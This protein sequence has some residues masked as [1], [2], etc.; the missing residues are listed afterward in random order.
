MSEF[1][2][3][4]KLAMAALDWAKLTYNLGCHLYEA[5]IGTSMKFGES[6]DSAEEIVLTEEN[7]F[8][9]RAGIAA[10]LSCISESPMLQVL[11]EQE[12]QAAEAEAEAECAP[13]H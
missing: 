6:E 5:P 13:L 9:F 7:I 11:K 8:V 10:M 1:T 4:E 3:Q 2:L 12:R